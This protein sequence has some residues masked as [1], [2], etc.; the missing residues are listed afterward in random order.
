VL[1]RI[2][3]PLPDVGAP[4][5]DP[6][7]DNDED[8]MNL[9]RGSSNP[10][11]CPHDLWLVLDL[12]YGRHGHN[13]DLGAWKNYNRFTVRVFWLASVSPLTMTLLLNILKKKKV[14]CADVN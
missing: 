13:V 2:P 1:D 10:P 12:G 8:A 3:A 14:C 7:C 11:H 9:L 4:P 6:L 5:S